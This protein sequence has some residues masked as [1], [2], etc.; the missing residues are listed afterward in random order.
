[1][2]YATCVSKWSVSGCCTL[3]VWVNEVWVDVVRYFVLSVCQLSTL[4]GCREWDLRGSGHRHLRTSSNRWQETLWSKDGPGPSLV[5][6]IST[7]NIS[8]VNSSLELKLKKSTHRFYRIMIQFELLQSKQV[9]IHDQFTDYV[10]SVFVTESHF[11]YGNTDLLAMLRNLLYKN[12][13]T[14]SGCGDI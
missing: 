2:L 4:S 12:T 1:M 5:A 10:S 11:E 6:F 9:I 7:H 13:E 3:L 14:F 8:L